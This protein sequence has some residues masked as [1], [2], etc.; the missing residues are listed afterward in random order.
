MLVNP[1]TETELSFGPSRKIALPF[2]PHRIARSRDGNTLAVVSE[3]AGAGVLLDI[4]T[5]SVLQRFKH[6]Q[7]TEFALSPD[8]QWIA[9]CG[10]H[11]DR[12]LLWNAKTG[13]MRHEWILGKET[14]VF[15]TPDSRSLIISRGDAFTFWDVATLKPVRR[16]DRDVR[17]YPGH[18]AFSHDGKLMALE[19]APAVIQLREVATGRIVAKLED[20]HGDRAQWMGFSPDGTQLVVS[21][22]FAK[23]IHVWDLRAIRTR[24][25]QMGLDWEWPEFEPVDP[26]ARVVAIQKVEVLPGDLPVT[27]EERA[28]ADI[29]EC[30]R[31][32]E[33]NPNNA[34]ACNE[35]AWIYLTGPLALRNIEASVPLAEKAVRLAGKETLHQNTLGVAYYRA[36]RYREAVDVLRPNIDKEPEKYWAFDLYFLAMSYHR[37]GESERAKDYL[38][39]A[40][41]WSGENRGLQ[42]SQ[43]E[44]LK[45]FRVEAEELLNAKKGTSKEK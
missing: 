30:R 27:R 14:G 2:A 33:A 31:D 3:D 7:A 9:S 35:L 23:A 11:S 36:R 40:V 32:L 16:L 15:F 20:P 6:P 4:A 18:V 22:R 41:R 17:I 12:V 44:E 28:R 26:K 13:V 8:G 39:W 5:E 45:E 19:M 42:A 21:A 25:K 1:Q 34:V 38:A 43:I 37:L 10:W 29:A 24:L